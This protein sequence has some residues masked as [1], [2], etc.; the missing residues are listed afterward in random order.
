VMIYG[1]SLL[2]ITGK[3]GRN[4]VMIVTDLLVV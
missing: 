3:L 1:Q 4:L 2:E